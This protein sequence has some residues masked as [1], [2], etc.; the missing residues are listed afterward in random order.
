MEITSVIVAQPVV[1]VGV[2]P[3]YIESVVAGGRTCS[4]PCRNRQ[5]RMAV[6]REYR[7]AFH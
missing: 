3:E 7:I 1:V 2:T 6:R 4:L 5:I